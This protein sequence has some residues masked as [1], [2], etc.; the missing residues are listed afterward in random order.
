M[1]DAVSQFVS[2]STARDHFGTSSNESISG[3]AYRL[4]LRRM[5]WIDWM[6]RRFGEDNHCANSHY[7]DVA[8][9]IQLVESEGYNVT[10]PE[11]RQ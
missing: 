4:K 9:A 6:F 8:R 1:W 2:V 11:P 5:K 7:Q 10:R 3:R